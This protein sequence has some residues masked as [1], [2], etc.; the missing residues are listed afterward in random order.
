MKTF[1]TNSIGSYDISSEQVNVGIVLA[2]PYICE[3][4]SPKEGVSAGQVNDALSK[5][6]PTGEGERIRDVLSYLR[7]KV[8]NKLRDGSRTHVIL[9]T[10]RKIPMSERE[11]VIEAIETLKQQKDSYFS[12][13]GM[14]KDLL[15]KD[16]KF[17]DHVQLVDNS[18]LLPNTFDLF[19]RVLK[20]IYGRFWLFGYLL[21]QEVFVFRKLPF[22]Y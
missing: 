3:I 16:F 9:L 15:E 11:N 1:I 19:D 12:V 5:I 7:E 8:F 6:V 20:R 14:S 21:L 18:R 4:L 10:V 2:S 17:F 22:S 13:I